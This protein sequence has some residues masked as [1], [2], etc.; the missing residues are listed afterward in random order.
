MI[1][2]WRKGKES[3]PDVGLLQHLR[4]GGGAGRLPRLL[5]ASGQHAGEDAACKPEGLVLLFLRAPS[6]S[7]C[8]CYGRGEA[9]ICARGPHHFHLG[10]HLL[11]NLPRTGGEGRSHLQAR[12]QLLEALCAAACP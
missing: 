1:K 2:R 9:P 11:D 8:V 12:A 10:R 7:L 6:V 5:Q 3:A 4:Q